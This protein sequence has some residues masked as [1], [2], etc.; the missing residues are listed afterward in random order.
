MTKIENDLLKTIQ[1]Q[2]R[3]IMKELST[4]LPAFNERLNG[5]SDKLN[6]IGS[7]LERIKSF[8]NDPDMNVALRIIKDY[9][10]DL[11]N[12]FTERQDKKKIGFN[13]LDKLVS[14]LI[15]GFVI[16]LVEIIVKHFSK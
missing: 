7:D 6:T 11:I 1:E 12:L 10:H 13:I 16:F 4:V 14:S 2:N 3:Q 15:I 9:R 5:F 8:T